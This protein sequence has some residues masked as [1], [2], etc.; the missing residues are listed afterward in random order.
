MS[1]VT[2][3]ISQIYTI[4]DIRVNMGT[5]SLDVVFSRTIDG[6]PVDTATFTLDGAAFGAIF[7][8]PGDVTKPRGQDLS[9]SLYN[10]AIAAKVIAGTLG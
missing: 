10:A 6:I 3:S 5:P 2:Q 7:G 1:V 8:V 9:D 4:T